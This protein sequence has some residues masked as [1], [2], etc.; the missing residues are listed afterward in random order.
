MTGKPK[1][2]N[3]VALLFAFAAIAEIKVNVI[4]K[5]KLPN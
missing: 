3:N 4:E 1:I 5:P 2:A